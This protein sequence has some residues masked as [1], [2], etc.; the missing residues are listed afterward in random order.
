[1][2]IQLSSTTQHGKSK[3]RLAEGL[4]ET[5]ELV[6]FVDPSIF[7]GSRGH[8]RGTD[9]RPGESFTVVLDPETRRRFATVI[10]RADGSFQVK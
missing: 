7:P 5:P 2:T 1:M 10:C 9:C 8:F 4:N 6:R 3:A